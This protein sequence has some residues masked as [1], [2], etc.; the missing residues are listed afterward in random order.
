MIMVKPKELS[1]ED[2]NVDVGGTNCREL[3]GMDISDKECEEETVEEEM[4][5]IDIVAAS[6]VVMGGIG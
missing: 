2:I 3:E 4:G 1:C 5:E 6:A